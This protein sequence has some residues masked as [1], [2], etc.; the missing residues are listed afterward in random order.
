MKLL[1]RKATTKKHRTTPPHDENKLDDEI[2]K[3]INEHRKK[4]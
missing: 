1:K 2:H 4:K 3:K